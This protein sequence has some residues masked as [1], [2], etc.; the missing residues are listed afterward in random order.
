MDGD[1][2]PM[3][4]FYAELAQQSTELPGVDKLKACAASLPY[5]IEPNSKMQ[6]MLD[7][8]IARIAQC[9]RAKD[10][11]P[12]FLQWESML[13]YWLL[14]KY[15]IP[16]EKRIKL[17][18]LYFAL[19]ITP[20]LPTHILATCSEGL[21]VLTRSKKKLSVK[22]MRLEWKAI[23]RILSKD[24]FLSR[25][26]FEISQTSYYMA[27]IAETARRFFHPAAIDEML[28]TFVPLLNGTDLNTILSS[29][30]YM[31]TFLPLSHPQTYLPMLFRLW[32]SINSYTYDERMLAFLSQLAEMHVDPTV[33]D[34]R[35]VKDIPDDAIGEEESR[36]HFDQSDLK[37]SYLW[38]GVTKEVG[39]FTEDEWKLIMCKCLASME[40]PLADAGSLTTGP[41]VDGQA[42]F[43]IGR[44]PKP[45]WRIFSLARII[46]YSMA[47]DGLPLAPSGVST[48]FDPPATPAR[49]PQLGD[50]LSAPLGRPG[51]GKKPKTYLAGSKA[52]DS[53]AKLILSTEHFFHPSNSGAWT[54]DLTAFIKYVTYEFNKRWHQEQRPDCKTPKHR[55][56]TVEMRS[57]LVKCLRTVAL[58]AMFSR[59]S[60]TVVNVQSA[61]KSMVVMEPDLILPPILERAIPSLEA[62]TETH[63]TIA[64]IKAL[65]AVA[66]AIVSRKNYYAG[67][68]YLLT[69]LEL[70][71][72]GIDLN[73]P[74][75]TL[76]T[77]AFLVEI[78]QYIKFGDL[79]EVHVNGVVDETGDGRGAPGF[80]AA[81]TRTTMRL[82]PNSSFESQF[83]EAEEDALVREASQGF[84][85]WV[86]SFFRRVILL[87]ENLPEESNVGGRAGG[88]VEAQVIDSVSGAC[89]QICVHLSEPLFD[90]VLNLIYDYATTTVRPNAVRAIHQLVECVANA[91]PAKTLA[92]FVPFCTRTIKVELDNGASSLRT[93]SASAP[94]PSDAT[95]HWNLAIL[96]GAMYNDGRA[97]MEFKADVLPL[98]KY[99]HQKTLSKRGFTYTGQLVRSIL[100]TLSH[101]YPLEN[102]FVNPEEWQSQEFQ[103]S[104]HL[105]W[106]KLYKQ[107]DVQV[108]WHV[109]NDAEIAFAIEILEDLISPALD[110]LDGLLETIST[111]TP[112]V[113][114]NEFCRHLSLVRY[115]FSGI[116]TFL[117]EHISD[118][119]YQRSF[120]TTDILDELPEFIATVEPLESGF[121]LKNP[122]DPRYQKV[123]QMRQRFGNFLH[124]AST[125]L[126]RQ[127]EENTVDAVQMLIRSIRTY[128]F[129]YGDNRDSYT[130]QRDQYFQELSLARQYAEQKVWP[131]ALFVR[132]AILYHSARL[133]WNSIERLRSKLEDSLIDDIAEWSMWHYA[134]V[135]SASQAVLESLCSTFD[136]C[137][138]RC[139]PV[140]Y[141]AL[142]LKVDDDRM[143]GALYTLNCP[144]FAKFAMSEPSLTNEFI[145]RLFACQH[146][147]KPS[148]RD[149][150]ATIW[151]NCLSI[152]V[153][154]CN[155][156]YSVPQGHIE[157]A[158]D[159]L[160]AVLP[161]T[162]LEPELVRRSIANRE[163]RAASHDASALELTRL[164]TEVAESPDTHWRYAIVAL[165]LL[166]TLIRR[167]QP[168]ETEHI[169]YMVDSVVDNHP[170]M[171]YYAQRCVMKLTRYIKLRTFCGNVANL[172][173]QQ[174]VNPLLKRKPI[175]A[176][177]HEFTAQYLASFRIPIDGARTGEE[178]LFQDKAVG[179]WMAWGSEIALYASPAQD[180]STFLPWEPASEPALQALRDV[181][182]QEDFWAR[183]SDH[184]A[185]ENQQESTTLDNISCVKSIFQV[186]EDECWP[187]VKPILEKLLSDVDQNKQRAGAELLAG[188]IGGSK[189]W[190]L[191][192][193]AVIWDWLTPRLPTMLGSK[194][195]TD[196]LNIWT[197]FVE[198]IFC[199]RDPRR[200]QPLVDFV[201]EQGLTTDYN[202]ES[203]FES[204]RSASFWR[205]MAEELGWRFAAWTDQWVER[206][207]VELASE[208]EEVRA[209]VAD[210]MEIS[211]KVRWKPNPSVPSVEVFVK[212]CRTKGP[213]F[214]IMGIRNGYHMKRVLDLVEQF[215][216]WRKERLPGTRAFQSKYDRVGITICKWL[217]QSFHDV[218]AVAA[219]DY[220]LPLMPELFR[221]EELHDNEELSNRA[222]LVL[223][224][225][226]GVTPPAAL[227]NPLIDGM[228]KAIRN[229]SSWKVRMKALPLLQVFY[230]RQFTMIS[231][232]KVS[233]ILEVICGC[234]DN[235]SVEVRELAATTLS[236]ILRCSPKRSVLMLK[237]RFERVERDTR[238]PDRKSPGYAMALRKLHSAILGV[239]A[240]IEAFPYSVPHW[241][242]DLITNVL[243]RHTYDPIPISTTVRKTASSFKKTHQDTW[244]EDALHFDEEQLQALGTLLSGT[245]YYA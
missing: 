130:V 75:K 9:I 152:F 94:L 161:Q 156:I 41:S 123:Y 76:C 107:E 148:I 141:K 183:L 17:A 95:L 63:R 225:M 102:R 88:D 173:L 57:E 53:L 195:K 147:E 56:L 243:S 6:R 106:G 220:I 124:R 86:T 193:Q 233:E 113:W 176:P 242:P 135:R 126:L 22:D 50:Y 82:D 202:G 166:R 221:F 192:K 245:S 127:G 180:K 174:S 38:T 1:P 49:F 3:D 51:G 204:S 58:L 32:E 28:A 235:E 21:S 65:G 64:V 216:K 188:V 217:F 230:F 157:K 27:T 153:E 66:L 54:S 45:T 200:S 184:Y 208:H 159:E 231:D 222:Q 111:E 198:Y 42:G 91:N 128:M 186:L 150:M 181:V 90:L 68:K 139:L 83:S 85:D 178:V 112:N 10:Y 4:A 52:L 98:L 71:I 25:R 109:P 171:R 12:G 212:E 96:R 18:K 37:S 59:D 185:E 14:L 211:G 67:A 73:D 223:V 134:S 129:E 187:I 227:V 196:T 23:Y 29:Q 137:R 61:L 93:T 149:C 213:D 207:F 232:E 79:S 167:D 74:S 105:Q 179:G 34:P 43:E 162:M 114:R 155:L 194:V 131:R 238:L 116:P 224:R 47:Q 154:P 99:L 8:F 13:A 175:A 240:L 39:I 44:L 244:H 118:E 20:G 125:C 190:S 97:I 15:P 36:V 205:A 81:D 172:A 46:V 119:E 7:F 228:F 209:Y 30:Y 234:L 199:N 84:A 219:F 110:T 80:N 206:H 11:D 72:P 160:E 197:T 40:I 169:K 168:A 78:S 104:H 115:G 117:K 48:P 2:P 26:Q 133:R 144:A 121:V 100:L 19:C 62:L 241:C 146:K 145:R 164:I 201:V 151:D 35:A 143:K 108:S 177:S 70:L 31:L 16:L 210:S 236:G 189:H 239:K 158:L 215:P 182:L 165:K 138:K 140:L 170:S 55:R 60:S 69:I 237:E 203:S 191:T 33:S 103:A 122:E 101:S 120:T 92:K 136:G 89:S 132:K 229:A 226:C 218:Q 5:S 87:M 77:T 163:K 142:D 214:D 24:L